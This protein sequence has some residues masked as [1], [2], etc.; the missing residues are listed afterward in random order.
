MVK[1]ALH[2]SVIHKPLSLVI[3]PETTSDL[4][5]EHHQKAEL[6]HACLTEA[7]RRFTQANNMP[8][9]TPPLIHIFGEATINK[10]AKQVLD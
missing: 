10:E 8:F 1:Q 4:R 2:K 3:A 5:K 7:G 9:L 6:E